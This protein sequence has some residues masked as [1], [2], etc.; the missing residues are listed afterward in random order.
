M[1]RL[2]LNPRRGYAE[3]LTMRMVSQK[4][5]VYVRNRFARLGR[6]CARQY[7]KCSRR[8]ALSVALVILAGFLLPAHSA[9]AVAFMLPAFI[10]GAASIFATAGFAYFFPQTVGD[11]VVG[12]L[13]WVLVTVVNIANALMTG[14]GLL[15]DHVIEFTIRSNALERVD[16][17]TVGWTVTRDFANLFFIFILLVIAIATILQIEK[18][19][20]KTLLARLII[21]ALLINFSLFFVKVGIDA[22][23]IIALQFY[24]AFSSAGG[25]ISSE[26]LNGLGLLQNYDPTKTVSGLT[27]GKMSV[28]LVSLATLYFVTAWTFFTG[29]LLLIGRFVAFIFLAVLAPL[30]FLLAILPSTKKHFDAWLSTLTNQIF[31]AP[32]YLFVLYIAILIIQNGQLLTRIAQKD[33]LD[34]TG[35]FNF[36]VIIFILLYGL[37]AVKNLSGDFGKT[38]IEYGNAVAG[39]A[40]GTIA[41][42]GAGFALRQTL[43]RAASKIASTEGFRDWAAKSR[44]G[45]LALKATRG[46]AGGSYDIRGVAPVT[47]G[48][49]KLGIGLGKVRGKGG[50][51]A[52]LERQTAAREQFGKSLGVPQ[53]EIRRVQEQI[54]EDRESLETQKAIA[55]SAI[56]TDD[57]RLQAT[58]RAKIIEGQ[59]RAKEQEIARLQTSR[60]LG[61]A[62]TIETPSI[63]TLFTKI[64]RKDKRASGTLQLAHWKKQEEGAKKDM[65]DIKNEMSRLQ[66]QRRRRGELTT[67]EESRV[68]EL[69][70]KQSKAQQKLDDIARNISRFTKQSNT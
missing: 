20:M 68:N 33:I 22:S 47:K 36:I 35:I 54:A 42:G 6:L 27:P 8:T 37:K 56:G 29:A 14:T 15:L 34:V 17:I 10:F 7:P 18:Y 38:A 69:Q 66:G 46:V 70:T 41:A 19:G 61:Y 9:Y 51:E 64:A 1:P 21:V 44:T 59:I 23:N 43:G 32:L 60:Q 5:Y 45:A 67:A 50:Y 65:Q 30:A 16:A 12:G 52:Q 26:I 40:G 11:F 39:F 58:Q 49:A 63:D 48:A 24:D 13:N 62:R 4:L 55:R 3:R 53:E 25:T 31:V 2:S 28:I 57:A